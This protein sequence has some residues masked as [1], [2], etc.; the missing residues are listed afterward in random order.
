MYA[1]EFQ[2]K[3]RNGTIEIPAQYRD[4]LG[5]TVK[6]IVL[7]E[8]E[9]KSGNFIDTLLETPLRLKGFKPLAREDIHA[10]A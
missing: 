10:R 9:D 6:V 1:V 7:A 2:A 4:K 8:A 3:V 5:Q